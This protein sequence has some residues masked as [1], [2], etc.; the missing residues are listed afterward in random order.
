MNDTEAQALMQSLL[1]ADEQLLWSQAA[2]TSA[3]AGVVIM[4]LCTTF[5][6]AM[7]VAAAAAWL[8]SADFRKRWSRW[9]AIGMTFPGAFFALAA[10]LYW[11]QFASAWSTA[12]G[13]TDQRVIIA[14]RDPWVQVASYGEERVRRLAREGE[15][16]DFDWGRPN[17]GAANIYRQHL[18]GVADAERVEQLIVEFVRDEAPAEPA[19]D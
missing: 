16:I 5:L 18:R 12:Y 4:A 6:A 1:Q 13:V 10:F 3:G 17:R 14:S 7:C 15:R 19:G 2:P 9:F 8:L 11:V